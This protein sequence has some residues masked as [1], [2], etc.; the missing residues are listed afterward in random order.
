MSTLVS[1]VQRPPQQTPSGWM[2]AM[3]LPLTRMGGKVPGPPCSPDGCVTSGWSLHLSGKCVVW[4]GKHPCRANLW[5]AC[6][7]PR[8]PSRGLPSVAAAVG[9]VDVA[10]EV[11]RGP[12][13]KD[14]PF[15]Y[16]TGKGM[17]FSLPGIP[18][19]A[20]HPHPGLCTGLGLSRCASFLM[21]RLGPGP[22]AELCILAWP[23]HW[24]TG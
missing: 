12:Y 15:C 22:A 19:L 3:R 20:V 13:D 9:S 18:A 11:T 8:S 7:P 17:D 6:E 5:G 16:P 24:A 23:C 1:C 2:K 4:V 21:S 14:K 10:W